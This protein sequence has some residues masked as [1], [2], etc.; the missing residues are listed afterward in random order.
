MSSFSTIRV[1]SRN[2]GR[3]LLHIDCSNHDGFRFGPL[4]PELTIDGRVMSPSA[5]RLNHGRHGIRS[6]EFTFDSIAHLTLSFETAAAHTVRMSAILRNTS[7]RTVVLNR[8]ELLK[9]IAAPNAFRLGVDPNAIRI[10]NQ[11]SY[12]GTVRPLMPASTAPAPGAN[13]SEPGGTDQPRASGSQILWVTY[14]R[15]ARR[16]FLAGFETSERWCGS[17]AMTTTPAGRIT[18]WSMGFDGGDLHVEPSA[19]I[20]LEDVLFMTSRDPLDLLDAYGDAVQRRHK[21]VIASRPPVSWCSWYPYRLGIT[22]ERMLTE[23]RAAAE[24]LRPLGLSIIETDLGWE[25]DQLPNTFEENAQ[26]RGGLK[27]LSKELRTMGFDLGAW[28]APFSISEFD[29][30]FKTHPEWLIKDAKGRP[31]ADGTWFWAPH[32]NVYILDLT[33]PGAQKWLKRRMV[34]LHR[35]GVRY[36]KLD[37]ISCISKNLAKNRFDTSIVGGGGVE[38]ARIGARIIREALPDALLLNCGGPEQPGTGQWDLQYQCQD[39]GNTGYITGEFQRANYLALACHLFK[40]RRWGYIQPSCLVVGLPG[41]IEEARLRATT[42]FL[43]AGQIDV[44]DTLTTLP[45]DRWDILT[46][47][48]PVMD[49]TARAIDLFDPVYGPDFNYEATCKQDSSQVHRLV[50][51]PPASVWHVHVASDWDE[52]DLIGLFDFNAVSPRSTPALTRFLIPLKRIGLSPGTS[53]WGYEFWS[54]QFLGTVPGGRS[55]PRGYTHPGDMQD[56]ACGNDPRTL[57]F[58]FFGPAARLVCVRKQRAH[59]WIVGTSFHQ[60]CGKELQNVRWNASTHTLRGTIR[61]PRGENGTIILSAAGRKPASQYAQVHG[62]R[63]PL[64]TG[65]NASLVFPITMADDSA[66]W[67]VRFA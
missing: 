5:A 45:E 31:A 64:R 16:S 20:P 56:F 63:V 32:G 51:H 38:T 7:D 43:T 26:F 54:R 62:Q 40:N 47:T 44:S 59:P 65:A 18:T 39:T 42:A 29:P 49:T 22:A 11:W 35:R 17:F 27:K 67:I 57:D 52:W 30:E 28:N 36:L 55:N 58:A 1:T 21:P 66:S 24:R 34:S 48:L 15:R 12:F 50:E 8:V 9:S 2:P 25:K 53:Y 23:A 41:T 10:M 37:F 6:A 33:H 60:S 19:A 14:D 4:L 13:A 61:R 3:G 46:A